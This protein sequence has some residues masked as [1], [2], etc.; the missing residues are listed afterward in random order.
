MYDKL[1]Y[2]LRVDYEDIW[3]YIEKEI[4]KYSQK[5][6]EL[7]FNE[8]LL[9]VHRIMIDAEDN[10]TWELIRDDI[11]SFIKKNKNF[12][13]Q[14]IDEISLCLIR[15]P[16][17]CASIK[18]ASHYYPAI[19]FESLCVAI[20]CNCTRSEIKNIYTTFEIEFNK[21]GGFVDEWS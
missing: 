16:L 8:M 10:F 18:Y 9:L 19:L 14:L 3:E 20:N 1:F 13:N 7:L 5:Q 11:I 4:N 21:N 12:D 6:W 2:V 17:D 15:Q